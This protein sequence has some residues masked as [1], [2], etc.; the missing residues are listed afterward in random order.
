MTIT[1]G[2]KALSAAFLLG[3]SLLGFAGTGHAASKGDQVVQAGLKYLGTP[4]EYA[5]SRSTKTTMDCSEFT[6]WA[7]K[8]GSGINMGRGG[9]NSQLKYIKANGHLTYN[10]ANLQ[11]GD[12]IFFMSY[13]GE[14][15]SKYAGDAS[16]Q[17]IS[18]VGI[19]MGNNKVLHTYSKDSGGV[20]ISNFKGTTWEKRYVSSGRPY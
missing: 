14:N 15:P 4:Y 2:M 13:R 20:K 5:S 17:P 16:K 10:K 1:Q 11:K 19:Y 7:Y 18:H 9:A 8:E 3:A 12:L 6:M